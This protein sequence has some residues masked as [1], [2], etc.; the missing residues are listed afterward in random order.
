MIQLD[1]FD[2]GIS[3]KYVQMKKMKHH[4]IKLYKKCSSNNCN[5]E[6]LNKPNKHK[7]IDCKIIEYPNQELLN[8]VEVVA[9]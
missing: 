1:L 9:K 6:I 4:K 7:C 3:D 2:D 5:N 8:V